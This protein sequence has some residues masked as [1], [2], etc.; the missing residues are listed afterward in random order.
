MR[1]TEVMMLVTNLHFS[2]M[3]D[4]SNES[5]M[6]ETQTGFFIT[7]FSRHFFST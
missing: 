1:K 4:S 3:Q 6:T 7:D 5:A 2:G